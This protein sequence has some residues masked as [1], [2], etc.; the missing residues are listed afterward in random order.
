MNTESYEARRHATLGYETTLRHRF[1]RSTWLRVIVTACLLSTMAEFPALAER[2]RAVRHPATPFAPP[3]Q[4]RV[5]SLFPGRSLDSGTVPIGLPAAFTFETWFWLEAVPVDPSTV[6]GLGV[7]HFGLFSAGVQPSGKFY[8]AT[9]QSYAEAS[10]AMVLRRWTHIA[11]RS[12]ATEF[13]LFV[14]GVKA[15]SG[16]PSSVAIPEAYII[17]GEYLAASVRQMRFWNVPLSDAEIRTFALTKPAVEDARLAA[18]WPM[19]DTERHGFSTFIVE[20]LGPRGIDFH[21]AHPIRMRWV[22]PEV[23]EAGPFF[24][25]R[26]V[27]NLARVPHPRLLDFDHDGDLDLYIVDRLVERGAEQPP[28]Y[29]GEPPHPDRAFRNDGDGMFTEVSDQV[30][31]GPRIQGYLV[32]DYF[33][34]DFNG[35]GLPDVFITENG[36]EYDGRDNYPWRNSIRI[37]TPQGTLV[38]ES[39]TRLD[40]RHDADHRAAVG[41]VDGDGDLDVVA[42]A[43]FFEEIFGGSYLFHMNDGT[44]VFTTEADRTPPEISFDPTKKVIP[45][46]VALVDADLDGDLDLFAGENGSNRTASGVPYNSLLLNDGSG[47]F[48]LA[49]A[50]W[51]PPKHIFPSHPCLDPP[52]PCRQAVHT[53]APLDLDNDGILD[54]VVVEFD[55]FYPNEGVPESMRR[56]LRPFLQVLLGNGDGSFRDGSSRIAPIW[57]VPVEASQDSQLFYLEK[58]DQNADGW[59]DLLVPSNQYNIPATLLINR[60]SGGFEEAGD[61]LPNGQPFTFFDIGD[62]DGDGDPD[63]AA[64]GWIL[65]NIKP[66]APNQFPIT[67]LKLRLAVAMGNPLV[68]TV[69]V[70]NLGAERAPNVSLAIP[71][72]HGYAGVLTNSGG[73]ACRVE[74]HVVLCTLPELAAG[75]RWQVAVTSNAQPNPEF[76]ATHAI[77]S[78]T[79][80]I[81]DPDLTDNY[82]RVLLSH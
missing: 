54:L 76:R 33:V 69:V 23:L 46:S 35:D 4:A 73:G 22:R 55:A 50:A 48:V 43:P 45:T 68:Q 39:S 10:T 9:P 41:D 56:P 74:G 58:L 30:L 34:E 13:S 29:E 61:I 25:A 64:D 59:Q 79:A 20:D 49:P 71:V 82:E 67:N 21:N 26:F 57:T 8:A 24:E 70:E 7:G 38:N 11:V 3:A 65:E 75:G 53:M 42:A 17:L 72:P 80:D 40:Q 81:R 78:V 36:P 66:Y 44:G 27:A 51:L 62:V 2:R 16:S 19:D 52:A 15:A 37:G 31:V 47:H 77:A 63:I 12:S 18:W 60:G 32:H 28:Y 14:D 1:A 6:V 5:L